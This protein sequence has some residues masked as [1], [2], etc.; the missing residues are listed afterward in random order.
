M[1]LIHVSL[2]IEGMKQWQ[3][4]NKTD[5]LNYTFLKST[6]QKWLFPRGAETIPGLSEKQE[7]CAHTVS[8]HQGR[9]SHVTGGC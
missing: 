2:K 1:V 5:F 4:S 3:V 7:E 8:D 6:K 9:K